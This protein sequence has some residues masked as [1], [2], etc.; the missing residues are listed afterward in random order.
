M[1]V[2]RETCAHPVGV[3]SCGM[4][5]HPLYGIVDLERV[6][7]RL[8]QGL[9]A[10]LV[11]LAD[12]YVL[13]LVSRHLGVYL[14]LAILAST[15]LLGAGFVLA[16]YRTTLARMWKRVGSGAYPRGELRRV[17]PLLAAGALLVVP[18]F[19]SDAIGLLLL[20]GPIGWVLGA[21]VE[22]RNRE[23]FRELY[24]YL[25]LRR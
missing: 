1:T 17:I 9:L 13:V 11:L 6:M 21:L 8:F 20:V 19:V 14:L 22:R 7:R 10:S 25:R 2:S 18:G 24:E 5:R 4:D 12:G 23:R 3:V 15:G 16:A